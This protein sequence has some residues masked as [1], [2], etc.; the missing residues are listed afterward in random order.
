M[1]KYNNISQSLALIDCNSFY[2]SCERVFNPKLIDKPVVV[3]S[4]NDGCIITRSDEAKKLGL[5]MGDPYFKV[6][7]I[8]EKNNVNVFSSNYCLYGDISDRVMDI[9]SRFASEI[10]IYS[11]DEAFLNL[12]GFKLNELRTYC[13]HIREIIN[14]WVGIPVSI[15]VGSTKTL[16]K[17]A[18][19]IAKK[20][21]NLKGVFILSNQDE[22]IKIL[23]KTEIGEIWGIGKQ[24]KKF[25]NKCGIETAKQ[26]VEMDRRWI[27]Q[28]MG[29]VGEKIQM[30]LNGI[31]CL[32][33]DLIPS[34]QK[35]CCVSRSFNK[36]IDNIDEMTESIATYASRAAEKIREENLIAQ[37]INVFITTNHFNQKEK[38]YSKSIRIQLD[39]P[40]N[41]N[42][43][44]VKRAIEGLYKIY[45]KKYRYKKVGVILHQLYNSNDVRGLLDYDRE[46]SDLLMRSID[47]INLK[48]GNSTLRLAAEGIE[49]KW[50]MQRKKIS[51][52]YTSRFHELKVVNC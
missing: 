6:K 25:L 40:T 28:N 21:K 5:R 1:Q 39:F 41:N 26:F 37:V 17:V 16:T 9:L 34:P 13:L 36:P 11:I 27:R 18:N 23:D 35:S 49:K 20:N 44:I 3:L 12:K 15:G 48:Y 30:E 50:K 10:E 29:V 24:L 45:K 42:F 14:K 51:P 32:N 33:L 38:Q 31:S 4:N 22:V 7:K 2:A 52:C 8:I 19:H 47:K 43:L 46:K